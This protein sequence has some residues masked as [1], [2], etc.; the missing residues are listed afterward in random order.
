MSVP[1]VDVVDRNNQPRGFKVDVNHA[2]RYG[3]W[4]RG[5]HIA[6]YTRNGQVLV[7]RRS[8]HILFY[9]D[10]LDISL[11]G[12]VEAGEEPLQTAVRELHE[13][14]GLKIKPQALQLTSVSRYNHR[15][16]RYHK[17]TRNVIYHYLL[18]LPSANVA[19]QLQRSE[20]SEATFMSLHDA[21]RLVKRHWL[22]HFGR[23]EGKYAM[24]EHLLQMV[25]SRLQETEN[26]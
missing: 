8:H 13:E 3:Q 6:I 20:V 22:P 25:E 11:G 2:T 1:I 26:H 4:F 7:E 19:I 9:P 15:W 12:I 24:Y 14:L 18:E 5:V 21:K 10:H 17:L 23:L 16:P